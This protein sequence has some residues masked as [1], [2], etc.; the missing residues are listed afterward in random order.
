MTLSQMWIGRR[1]LHRSLPPRHLGTG[2]IN[3]EQWSKH[4][5]RRRTGL[6]LG[7]SAGNTGG[8]ASNEAP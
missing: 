5:T 3:W 6:A 4:G 7:R 8:G 2:I 1:T